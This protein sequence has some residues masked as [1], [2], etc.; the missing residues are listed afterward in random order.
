MRTPLSI[1]SLLTIVAVLS[2]AGCNKEAADK[3]PPSSNPTAGFFLG[4]GSEP[5]VSLLA[6]ISDPLRFHGKAIKVTGI[7]QDT[8]E[9]SGLFPSRDLSFE[10]ANGVWV[11]FGKGMTVDPA[12]YF[13]L[14]RPAYNEG[15]VTVE[16]I[17]D[18]KSHGHLGQWSATLV[19]TKMK[20]SPIQWLEDRMRPRATPQAEPAPNQK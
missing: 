15:W 17:I 10:E 2:L 19:V 11:S 5:P 4:S 13:K 3:I 6:V 7:Y 18:A 9:R 16:G 8:F 1:L 20:V 12:D 14:P